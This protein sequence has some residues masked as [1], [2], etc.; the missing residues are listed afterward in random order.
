MNAF[1]SFTETGWQD[2]PLRELARSLE[3]APPDISALDKSVVKE[4][5]E[6]AL[7]GMGGFV[8]FS[9]YETLR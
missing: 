1:F 5:A 8:D 9:F 2:F 3:K 6:G 7:E 4:L